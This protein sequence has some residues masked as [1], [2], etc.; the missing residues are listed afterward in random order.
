VDAPGDPVTVAELL[1]HASG[2]PEVGPRMLSRAGPPVWPT[3]F[4]TL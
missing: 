2:I 1:S 4:E 3:T